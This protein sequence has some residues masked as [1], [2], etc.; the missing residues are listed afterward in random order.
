M[1]SIPRSLQLHV[2]AGP[3]CGTRT[4]TIFLKRA[5]QLIPHAGVPMLRII[6][7]A[8][9]K[10][11]RKLPTPP[12]PLGCWMTTVN[13]RAPH[14]EGMGGYFFRFHW[15]KGV[16]RWTR[17]PS[18]SSS[19]KKTERRL[20]RKKSP[21]WRK[22]QSPATILLQFL[23]DFRLDLRGEYPAGQPHREGR[24]RAIPLAHLVKGLDGIGGKKRG[25]VWRRGQGEGKT[26]IAATARSMGNACRSSFSWSKR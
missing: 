2:T 17:K 8:H 23:T 14:A 25:P 11:R 22:P 19:P 9:R 18:A 7:P 13:K 21:F 4:I 6:H 20:D 15:K 5:V 26:G 24:H 16:R 12:I 3:S 10:E 1:C